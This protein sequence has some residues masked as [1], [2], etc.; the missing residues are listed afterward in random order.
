VYQSR[1]G[2]PSQPWLEPDICAA[3]RN[4]AASQQA[5]DVVVVPIGFISDHIEVVYDLDTEAR[6]TGE[7]S[8]INMVRAMTVG[9]H[10]RFVR[11]IRELIEERL[12]ENPMRLTLGDCGPSHDECPADCCQYVPVFPKRPGNS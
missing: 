8:G 9:T 10:P 3:L 1:S 5:D 4:L 12:N 11:M 2:P 6:R 7:Q